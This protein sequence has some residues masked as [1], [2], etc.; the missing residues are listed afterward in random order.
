M[1]TCPCCRK[2]LAV[3]VGER[4]RERVVLLVGVS[5]WRGIDMNV[6]ILQKLFQHFTGSNQEIAVASLAPEFERIFAR[7]LRAG[8]PIGKSSPLEVGRD[9]DLQL[10]LDVFHHC[11]ELGRSTDTRKLGTRR[12]SHI[13]FKRNMILIKR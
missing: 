4:F 13:R 7:S 11:V 8:V 9:R 3:K 2:N 5:R 12:N 6:V 1:T 10:A